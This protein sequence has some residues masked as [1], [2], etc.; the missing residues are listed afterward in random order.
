MEKLEEELYLKRFVNQHPDNKMGWYLLGRYYLKEGKEAKANYCFIQSGDVYEA[1][2][3]ESHPLAEKQGLELLMK[4]DLEQKKRKL[5]RKTL[6]ILLPM[7]LLAFLLPLQAA[8]RVED[9]AETKEAA[10]VG[11]ASGISEKQAPLGVLLLSKEEN[12][13]IEQALQIFSK[14]KPRVLIAAELKRSDNWL[15]WNSDERLLASIASNGS[16]SPLQVELL[17]PEL[18]LCEPSSLPA[19]NETFQ[20]W[21][22]QQEMHWT[23]SSA[24]YHYRELFQKWPVR[25]KDLIQPYPNNVLAGEGKGMRE[26]FPRLLQALKEYEQN[27]EKSEQ[28]AVK[29]GKATSDNAGKEE[30]GTAGGSDFNA[31]S[32]GTNGLIEEGWPDPIQIVVDTEAHTLSVVHNLLVIRSYKVGLGGDRT[33]TGTFSISEKVRNPNGS[34]QGVF[35]SRGMTLSNTLYAIHGTDKEDSILKDESLGC[36]RMKRGDVEELFDM[37]PLGTKVIIKKGM[38]PF[39]AKPAPSRFRL[40]PQQNE[41]NPDKKYEWL[42]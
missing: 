42:S 17:S 4:W 18:C 8:K 36:I 38:I 13:P 19:M 27:I 22:K 2:E 16:R 10:T 12:A 30:V 7:L 35:G 5:L 40:E 39:P 1:Y 25:L 14:L 33:P 24:I 32:M 20:T 37:V 41:T 6:F 3:Q 15:D 26:M 34:D 9:A 31:K 11:G 28:T 21:K 29:G 23:L